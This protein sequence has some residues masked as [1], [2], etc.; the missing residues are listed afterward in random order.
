MKLSE[1]L[2]QESPDKIRIAD[3]VL[4]Y[5][6]IKAT[7]FCFIDDSHIAIADRTH[8][9]IYNALRA[10]KKSAE[11]G[12]PNFGVFKD[13]GV[14]FLPSRPS[15]EAL[16]DVADKLVGDMGGNRFNTYSGRVWVGLRSE[17]IGKFSAISFWTTS[18]APGMVRKLGSI[19]HIFKI[20]DE[21]LY[22][23][24]ID[25]E[26]PEVFNLGSTSG[27][28]ISKVNPNLTQAQIADILK[29]AHFDKKSLTREERAVVDEF[30]PRVTKSLFD[31]P[32]I[33]V[34]AKASTSESLV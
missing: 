30:R 22:V 5:D 33:S 29:R 15:K 14:R 20:G 6:H 25:S 7:T 34:R 4:E 18:K 11:L 28:L 9:F 21:P 2:L 24:F 3:M 32:M 27:K 13:Y 1:R 8:I 16:L 31:E 10:F 17:A 19:L 12:K 23:E 26:Q